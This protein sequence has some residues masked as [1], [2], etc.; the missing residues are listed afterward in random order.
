ML[1]ST[2]VIIKRVQTF[3]QIREE[4]EFFLVL[5]IYCVYFLE[6]FVMCVYTV[7][8]THVY[9]CMYQRCNDLRFSL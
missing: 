8:T 5:S 6:M 3:R 2:F 4:L 1:N 9:Y 7:W